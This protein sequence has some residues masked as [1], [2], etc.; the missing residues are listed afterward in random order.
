MTQSEPVAFYKPRTA[1]AVIIANMIGTGVFTSLGFQLLDI[2]TGFPLLMLWVLGGVAALCGA[3]SY[4]ELGAALPRSGGEYN[5]LGRIYHPVAGFI[6]GWISAV[7]GFAAPVAASAIVFAKY[8]TA[9]LPGEYGLWTQKGLA[10]TI[11]LI[12]TIIHGRSRLGS[13]RFQTLFTALKISLI[14]VF[15]AAGIFLTKDVTEMQFTPQAGDFGKMTSGAF[16][17]ALIYVS[18]GYAGW[19]AATYIS[20]EMK[21]P[22]RDLPRVLLIGTGIVMSL[23]VALNF[24]FL[25]VAPIEAMLGKEEVGYIAAGYIFGE[26]G[27][28]AVGFMLSLLLISTVSAMV[29]AGPRAL[30]AVGEDFKA[31]SFLGKTNAGGVPRNAI[32]F[33]SAITLVFILTSSF[34]FIVV[35]AGAVLALNSLLAVIGVFVLRYREPDLPRPYRTWGYPITPLIYIALTVFT[36]LFVI[37]TNPA[38]ALFALAIITIGGAFYWLSERSNN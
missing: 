22:Q 11:V 34:E 27:A 25:R 38:K 32:Y 30:Q 35:F 29:L 24:V 17:V 33:Q 26:S 12:A 31:L 4:A 16:A 1:A 15:C 18:Y 6:S 5:F 36:L 7:I 19:N 9:A 28:R 23:Y 3:A 21:H 37:K 8:F 10:V 2:Q 13:A 20:G 14:I